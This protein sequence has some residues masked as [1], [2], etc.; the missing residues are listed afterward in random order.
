MIGT[1]RATMRFL[2]VC[3]LTIGSLSP[4][5]RGI[6]ENSKGPQ[7]T[8]I[9]WDVPF[10]KDVVFDGPLLATLV[11]RDIVL[12]LYIVEDDGGNRHSELCFVSLPSGT[13][14][15]LRLPYGAAVKCISPDEIAV[16]PALGQE[17]RESTWSFVNVASLEEHTGP[18]IPHGPYVHTDG[19]DAVLM[20]AHENDIWLYD[21]ATRQQYTLSFSKHDLDEK[22]NLAMAPG[23][24]VLTGRRDDYND[25]PLPRTQLW[26]FPELQ[27]ITEYQATGEWFWDAEPKVFGDYFAYPLAPGRWQVA[28][29]QDGRLRFVLGQSPATRESAREEYGGILLVDDTADYVRA[30]G[31]I[32]TMEQVSKNHMTLN[33]YDIVTGKRVRTAQMQSKR[34]GDLSVHIHHLRVAVTKIGEEWV[35]FEEVADPRD[36]PE[37]GRCKMRLIPYRIR[38]FKTADDSIGFLRDGSLEPII[39]NGRLIV[40]SRDHIRI[41]SLTDALFPGG[42]RGKGVNPSKEAK[43]H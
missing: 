16:K 17:A 15:W 1:R 36:D 7:F 37:K 28:A 29:L 13:S 30:T 43:S 3:V 18:T 27:K 34:L 40:P 9:R 38:D 39:N 33:A 11:G 25:F 31:V 20:S 12:Y 2:L 6:A 41:C 26:S 32:L 35:L 24:I 4:C 23:R 42:V 14:R 22:V 21:R 10:A 5:E 19:L 8:E